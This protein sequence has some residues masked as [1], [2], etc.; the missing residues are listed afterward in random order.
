MAHKQCQA[1]TKQGLPCKSGAM[2]NSAF[3]GPHTDMARENMAKVI[4]ASFAVEQELPIQQESQPI[5]F[6][7]YQKSTKLTAF[8]PSNFRTAVTYTALGLT[9]EA[10]EVA[11]KVKKAIRDEQGVFSESRIQAIGD[12]IGD[13]LW[14]CA[15]LADELGLSLN[16][17]ASNN[18][19]KL[20][21]RQEKG[22]LG[23]DGDNR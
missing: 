16:D 6:N 13:V 14:Y 2:P 7:S 15:R 23:G 20:S 5:D 1:K 22:T 10:G 21:A 4:Q 8:Y 3:C 19:S 17:I 11:G 12:E 9:S 18:L